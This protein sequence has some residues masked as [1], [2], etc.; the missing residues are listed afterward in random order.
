[1]SYD[2]LF[3]AATGAG[4]D[5]TP[6]VM[7]LGFVGVGL[8]LVKN[9]RLLPTMFPGGLTPRGAA[10]FAYFFLGL[11]TLFAAGALFVPPYDYPTLQEALVQGRAHVVEGRVRDFKDTYSGKRH[12]S[13]TVCGVSFD[14]RLTG[15][16]DDNRLRAVPIREGLW[17]RIAY[18]DTRIGRLEVARTDPG[19]KSDCHSPGGGNTGAAGP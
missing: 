2:L 17:V 18:L 9:R 10:A 14:G 4:R 7:T 19:I 5:W 11:S 8:F 3:D 1:M 6:V 12:E 16:F 13:F 15:V